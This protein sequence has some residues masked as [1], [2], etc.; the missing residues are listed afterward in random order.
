MGLPLTISL[1]FRTQDMQ[2]EEQ[3]NRKRRRCGAKGEGR[4]AWLFLMPSLVGY[5]VF[6]VLPFIMVVGLSF[7]KYNIIT[8]AQWNNYS[9][10]ILLKLDKRFLVTLGNSFRFLLLLVPMHMIMGLALAFGVNAV[11]NKQLVYTFRTIYYFPTLLAT[12]SIAIA[13][14]MILNQDFGILNYYLGLLGVEKIPWLSTS[15]WVYPATMLFS[16]WKFVG[17]YFL[18]FLI[19]LQGIDRSYLEAA[20]IDG[21]GPWQKARHIT[22][23]LLSPTLFF[24]FVTMM[25]GTIQIFDEPYILTG[26]GPGDASRSISLYIYQTAFT[27]QKFGY[28]AAQSLVLMVIVMI[29]TLAQFRFSD[30]WVSY[31]RD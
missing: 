1:C 4:A 2:G 17:G 30:T 14:T 26:G 12:S 8:P 31:E 15:K 22:F 3:V 29:I 7:T 5:L 25:I 23:P 19:G 13:W 6:V 24:V 9:N 27:S 20:E 11:K 10:W 28:A 16:L 21:A 18:Y